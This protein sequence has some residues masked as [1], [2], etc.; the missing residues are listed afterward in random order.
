MADRARGVIRE[1]ILSIEE[2]HEPG[3]YG[4]MASAK[5]TIRRLKSRRRHV[6]P[7]L[8]DD[9]YVSETFEEDHV[10][11]AHGNSAIAEWKAKLA[12]QNAPPPCPHCGQAMPGQKK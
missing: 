11:T 9:Y 5:I 4:Y 6:K 12:A 2:D 10:V 1:T 7:L 8:G 3:M